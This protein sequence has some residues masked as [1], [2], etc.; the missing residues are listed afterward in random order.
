MNRFKNTAKTLLTCADIGSI[1][2][3][4][5]FEEKIG[6]PISISLQNSSSVEI[7][8][9]SAQVSNVL[10]VFLNLFMRC[11]LL[12]SPSA[13]VKGLRHI[14]AQAGRPSSFFDL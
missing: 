14:S 1:S 11:P 8:P 10:A 7:E 12:I 3:L 2:T 13:A 6:N 5:E 9:V 4:D